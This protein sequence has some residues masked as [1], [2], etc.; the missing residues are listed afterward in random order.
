LSSL[1]VMK[2]GGTSMGSADR[3]RASAAITAAERARRPVAIVV[4]AMSKVT[5]MLLDTL[6]HAE[7]GDKPTMEKN[8]A[9]LRAKHAEA[10]EGLLGEKAPEA[11]SQIN[12]ILNEFERIANG[13]LL[14]GDRPPR[15]TK[16]SPSANGSPRS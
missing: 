10:A 16:P 3:I 13:I 4:S 8:I 5:D 2:F 6:R 15:S 14:L 7:S 1:I 9:A 12:A 11:V